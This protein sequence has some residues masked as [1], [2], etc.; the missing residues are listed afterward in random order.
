M[1]LFSVVGARPQF[2]KLGMI[3]LALQRSVVGKIRH[4]V[5]HT[6]Q[7]YDANL[8]QI[9]F[10]ELG[11]PIPDENLGVGSGTH[12]GQTAR[13]LE[14]L[15]GLF[16]RERPD[17]V[18][19]YGD[20][21][22]TLAAAL[23]AAKLGV[24]VA[25]VESGLRSYRKSMPEEINRV[26]TD[27]LSTLLFC[28]TTQ[29]FAN[30][31]NEG[32]NGAIGEGSLVSE[33]FMAPPRVP[34]PDTPWVVNV[35][36]V[37]YDSVLHHVGRASEGKSTPS[38]LPPLAASYAV[39]TVHRAENT[40]DV[41]RLRGILEAASRI[42][43]GGTPVVFPIHP[44]TRAAIERESLA[45][46]LD[47]LVVVEPVSYYDM[48]RLTKDAELV[49]TDSGGL[50]R[51]AFM[52]GRPCVT[53]RDETE[54]VELLETGISALGG[55]DPERILHATDRVT[56]CSAVPP[57]SPYGDGRAADRIVR[58]LRAWRDGAGA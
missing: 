4:R 43:S 31:A 47:E 6:G 11:L 7:H 49:I 46:L 56:G 20:T 42:A 54:W 53:L 44:R 12:G 3:D 58:I 18:L 40:D 1:K 14:A 55:A 10:E 51:E 22:S 41:V 34:S 35:G 8:S 21:N 50:Q 32:I 9:F 15:D 19:T 38:A 23:A 37:M 16:A 30:L 29:A 36:D 24:P 28:P 25:H 39:M 45:A 33:A 52:L 2:I 57:T 27:H 48:L 17:L 13:M 26:L 5:V